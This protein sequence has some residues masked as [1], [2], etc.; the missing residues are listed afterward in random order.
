[1]P[2]QRQSTR[3]GQHP[4]AAGADV[5]RAGPGEIRP[6]RPRIY[7]HLTLPARRKQGEVGH[8]TRLKVLI[9]DD[10]PPARER[11]KSLLA[12]IPDMD[13]V[14]EAANGQQSLSRTHEL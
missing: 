10:E 12:E 9:V 6:L 1:C 8:V 3:P 7:C 5:R 4:G 2:H 13:V 11:L 14:G